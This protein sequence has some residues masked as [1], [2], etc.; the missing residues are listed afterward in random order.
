M[1]QKLLKTNEFVVFLILVG[2]CIIIGFINPAF[3][4]I[5]TI[6]DT[7][8]GATVFYI[9]AFALLPIIIAGGVDMSF[10]AMAAVASFATH[11]FLIGRGYEGGIWL[12][13]I[14]ACFIGGL[15]G[16]FNGFLVTRFKLPIFSVSLATFTMWYGF[17]LFF[18][19]STMNFN[20]PNGAVGYYENNLI[21]YT[22]PVMGKTGLNSSILF[23]VVAGLFIWW[24]LKYTTIGRGVFAI[25]GNREVAVRSGFNVKRILLIIFAI[26]GIFAA[27]AGVL[28]GL[29]NRF[30]GP[31]VLMGNAL[32]VIAAVIL[33]GA[34]INGGKGTVIGTALGVTL[35]QVINR[36]L[37]LCGIPAEW[38]KLVVGLIL[39]IFIS[40]PALR[41]RRENKVGHTTAI[42]ELE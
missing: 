5:A 42:T 30:F 31:T 18:I 14:I 27:V 25:G 3:F 36:A 19:G 28:Y 11:M 41:A 23:V 15:M 24:F 1:I 26:M 20:L 33:G 2:L 4:S 8:R 39:I 17:A 12:Y 34:S 7:L 38:Q 32:D 10:V 21:T 13:F 40:L 16:L 35:I 9:L 37:I 22:D 6:F 29:L